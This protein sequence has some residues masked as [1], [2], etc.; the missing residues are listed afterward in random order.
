MAEQVSAA[1]AAFFV[2]LS[3]VQERQ[4]PSSTQERK[5]H[6]QLLLLLP[7]HI[8]LSFTLIPS[9]GTTSWEHQKVP[10]ASKGAEKEGPQGCGMGWAEGGLK[11]EKEGEG[12]VASLT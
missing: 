5:Q 6:S 7:Q 2:C 1:A 9:L 11:G 3:D 12:G 10:A 8:L 4:H